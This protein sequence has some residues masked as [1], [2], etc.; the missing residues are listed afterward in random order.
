MK[1]ALIIAVVLVLA[2]GCDPNSPEQGAVEEDN[3][4]HLYAIL[5]YAQHCPSC[6]M[7]NPTVRAVQDEFEGEITFLRFDMSDEDTKNASKQLA[8]EHELEE[9]YREHEDKTGYLIVVSEDGEEEL[10]RLS[11]EY[12]EAELRA[13][14]E[15]LLDSG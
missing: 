6:N 8:A 13:E 9:L 11:G 10:R 14:F 2:F 5:M 3:A 12:E 4:Q 15:G 1:Q 7:L